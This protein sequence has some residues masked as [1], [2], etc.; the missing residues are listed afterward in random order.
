MEEKEKIISNIRK[1]AKE[2]AFLIEKAHKLHFGIIV[3]IENGMLDLE[4]NEQLI[5]TK[6]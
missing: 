1:K 6:L 4:L 2:I 5:K 3:K